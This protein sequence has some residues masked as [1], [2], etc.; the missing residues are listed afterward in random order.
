[1]PV[2]VAAAGLRLPKA[3]ACAPPSRATATAKAAGAINPDARLW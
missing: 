3:A 1:M 2:S